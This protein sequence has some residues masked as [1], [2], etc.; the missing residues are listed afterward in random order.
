MKRSLDFIAAF[1]I[2]AALLIAAAAT[3]GAV[4]GIAVMAFEAMT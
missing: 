3:L 4:I 2:T 1:I